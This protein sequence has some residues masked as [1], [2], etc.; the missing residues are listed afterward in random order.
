MDVPK[1][2]QPPGLKFNRYRLRDEGSSAVNPHQRIARQ[3]RHDKK[4]KRLIAKFV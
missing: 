3:K 1:I 2:G 4:N